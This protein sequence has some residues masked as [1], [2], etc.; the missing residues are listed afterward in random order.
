MMRESWDLYLFVKDALGF[1]DTPVRPS[2]ASLEGLPCSGH[3][4]R[5]ALR[6]FLERRVRFRSLR[7]GEDLFMEG[8]DASLK[9]LTCSIS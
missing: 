1:V 2:N 9:D 8:R 7:V 6:V 4:G 3:I 5:S